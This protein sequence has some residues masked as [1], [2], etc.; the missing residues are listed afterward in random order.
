M[1]VVGVKKDFDK[2]QA[3]GAVNRPIDPLLRLASAKLAISNCVRRPAALVDSARCQPRLLNVGSRF[4]LL[5]F[6]AVP[7]LA[8]TPGEKEPCLKGRGDR[9]RDISVEV[10]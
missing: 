2:R 3:M 7:D 9:R 10:D 5:C 1:R 4:S 8:L 6:C